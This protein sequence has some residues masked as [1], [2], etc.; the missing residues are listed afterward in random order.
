MSVAVDG[1]LLSGAERVR[2]D[3]GERWMDA[4]DEELLPFDEQEV[5][6]LVA[7]ALALLL[8]PPRLPAATT[9]SS[10][11]ILTCFRSE[12]SQSKKDI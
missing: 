9:F 4:A 6:A 2:F 11:S 3:A 5:E 7:A 8:L 1:R 10:R 12:R